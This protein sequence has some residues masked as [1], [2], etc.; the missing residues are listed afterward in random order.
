MPAELRLVD[1]DEHAL[2]QRVARL[3]AESG[4]GYTVARFTYWYTSRPPVHEVVLVPHT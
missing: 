4:G 1:G 3:L 2:E